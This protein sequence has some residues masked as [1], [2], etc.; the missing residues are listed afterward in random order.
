MHTRYVEKPI[1][2][3]PAQFEEMEKPPPFDTI[4]RYEGSL[5]TN[6]VKRKETAEFLKQRAQV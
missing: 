4:T 2:S 3:I 1:A 6:V 5:N